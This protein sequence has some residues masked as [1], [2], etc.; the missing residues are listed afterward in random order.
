M[1]GTKTSR[2]WLERLAAGELDEATAAQ[3]K[4]DLAAEGRSWDEERAAI[5]ASNAAFRESHPARAAAAAIRQRAGATKASAPARRAPVLVWATAAVGMAAAVIGVVRLDRGD[6][7]AVGT[8]YEPT[9]IKYGAE[10]HASIA[11]YRRDP[12]GS[13]KLSAG[14]AAR[15]GDLLEVT[16]AVRRPLHAV[17]VSIDGR[18]H[19]TRHLPDAG[20]P[21]AARLAI[22]EARLGSSYELDDAPGFE[23]FLLVTREAPFDAAVALDAAA[24]LARDPARARTGALALPPDFRQQAFLLVKPHKELP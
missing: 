3:V 16:I 7:N 4:R 5:E 15:A 2:W 18:G 9:R 13:T 23:R 14:A 8:D 1:A 20:Q 6:T 19:V 24:A 22:G 11:V 21:K 17:L 10:D 12:R